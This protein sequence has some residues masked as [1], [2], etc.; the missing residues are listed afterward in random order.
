VFSGNCL[1]PET[2]NGHGSQ[3]QDKGNIERQLPLTG[4]TVES[5]WIFASAYMFLALSESEQKLTQDCGSF[6]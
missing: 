6:Q 1:S 2:D 4:V 5:A 3:T